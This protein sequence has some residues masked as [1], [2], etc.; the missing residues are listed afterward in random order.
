MQEALCY[1]LRKRDAPREVPVWV[2]LWPN[3]IIKDNDSAAVIISADREVSQTPSRPSTAGRTRMERSGKANV[4]PRDTASE[5]TG[6]FIAVKK[7][8]EAVPIQ[9]TR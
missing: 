9:L 7:E 3:R 8:L 5:M 1:G 6:R 2:S 4:C